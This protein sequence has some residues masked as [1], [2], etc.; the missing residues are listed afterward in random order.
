[1]AALVTA[2]AFLLLPSGAEGALHLQKVARAG[3]GYGDLTSVVTAPGDPGAL[4]VTQRTGLIKR[5]KD[6]RSTNFLDLRGKVRDSGDVE[7]GLFSILFAPG[8]EHRFY[9]I[10]SDN[11]G[12]E[13]LDEFRTNAAG[14]ARKG[15]RRP[16][17]NI[18]H[19]SG[20][21]HYAGNL[22]LGPD[23][24]LYIST[25]DAQDSA[26]SQNLG[27]LLG[28][29]LRID[30]RRSNGRP[31]TVPGSNPFVGR[32]GRDEIW[33][34]G[35]RNPFRFSFDRS[36]G[37]LII[38]DVGDVSQ[39]EID[40]EPRSAGAGRGKNFG[41]PCREGSGDG[42]VACTAKSPEA[43]VFSYPHTPIDGS[44][45]RCAIIGGFVARGPGFG[46]VR[47]RYIYADL[48]AGQI[49]SV[50]LGRRHASG[51]RLEARLQRPEA[52]GEDGRGRLYVV[53]AFGLAYRLRGQSGARE[54]SARSSQGL[55]TA[56]VS[57]LAL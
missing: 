28:K 22:K 8:A 47:G 39:E 19:R 43:P 54:L 11:R 6:G 16:V 48:C 7:Q 15:S 52:F 38:G 46:G 56:V 44:E 31:Y 53:S 13:Q 37:A 40:F 49:R 50:A 55:E 14:A 10:Y 32:P 27:S 29:I 36:S 24:Y 20:N 42:P 4:Y 23:G 35:L 41:W 26:H 57:A 9:V 2:L 1:M 12:D 21:A 17:L 45:P 30:P 3:N 25:G 51:D 5:L 33:S 34:Y 18:P